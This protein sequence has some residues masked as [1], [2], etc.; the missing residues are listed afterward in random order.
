MPG[1]LGPAAVL[2][3]PGAVA[4]A[5]H[6]AVRAATSPGVTSAT[7]TAILFY[8]AFGKVPEWVKRDISF[9]NLVR[10]K[11]D[12]S[13]EDFEGLFSVVGKLQGIAGS[14]QDLDTDIPQIYAALLAFIQLSGQNKLQQLDL[15]H[16]RHRSARSGGDGETALDDD[17]DDDASA[18]APDDDGVPE[19]TAST[20]D[21]I[22]ESS[23]RA[24]ALSSL[25]TDDIRTALKLASLAYH[26]DPETLTEKL[27]EIDF[28]LL[29]HKLTDTR[30]G[31][32]AYYVA[33]SP[34]R[35]RVVIGFRGTSTLGDLMTDCCGTAVPL[36]ED[37][38]LGD[39]ARVEIKAAV[40]NIVMTGSNEDTMEIISGH[41]RI[42]FEDH[43]DDGDNF[44]RCHEGILISA[45]NAM[46]EIEPDLLPLIE[47][48]HRVVFCGHSLG[49][50]TA[51]LATTL[52]RSRFPEFFS[53]PERVHAY[54]FGA[55]PVLDHD[56]AI[57]ARAYCTTVVNNADLI[58]RLN[59]TNL[60]VALA[61]LRRI[62][63]KLVERELCPICPVTSVA[64]LNKIAEGIG[65]TPLMT[66]SELNETIHE[67]HG[68]LALRKPEHLFVPGRVLLVY[69]PWGLDLDDD[70]NENES[71]QKNAADDSGPTCG[72]SGSNEVRCVE[73]SGTSPVFQR[74]EIDGLRCFTDHLASAYSEIL[75]MNFDF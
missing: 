19:S 65:G 7:L 47:S 23:G 69:E 72:G 34:I 51:V 25:R 2:A 28:T 56:S 52:L 50:G 11:E 55:P 64:F 49:A 58:S 27:D 31:Q 45:R 44:I 66:P 35:K 3:G 10:N 53:T 36:A 18:V 57:A 41:E 63:A 32:T 30:P 59:I 60:A 24:L 33:V 75:G 73:T 38:S 71:D 9:K 43:D 4:A 12:L 21:T 68:N 70:E 14:I 39:R 54:A 8:W 40:P 26:E 29:R 1:P 16:R 22:Y 20:R 74:L 46:D 17:D 5:K 37:D 67:A 42:V 62:Q 61:C 13:R 6:L 48:G 15:D